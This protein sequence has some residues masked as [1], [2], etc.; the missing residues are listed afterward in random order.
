MGL[1][2]KLEK[3]RGPG[4]FLPPEAALSHTNPPYNPPYDKR[5]WLTDRARLGAHQEKVGGL[6]GL[7]PVPVE[8]SDKE[9]L[10]TGVRSHCGF[11]KR[12]AESPSKS[13]MKRLNG[14]AKKKARRRPSPIPT[15]GRN[16]HRC[17]ALRPF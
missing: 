16:L 7:D 3:A 5:V 4:S 11:R 1:A 17:S 12:G 9:S 14:G 13:G 2:M 15:P 8:A 6:A 10:P